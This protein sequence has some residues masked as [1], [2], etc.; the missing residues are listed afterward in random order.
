M[1]KIALLMILVVPCL[2]FA[3]GSDYW[4]KNKDINFPIG[5]GTTACSFYNNLDQASEQ[6][7]VLNEFYS[8]WMDGWVSSFAVYSDWNIRNIEKTE[9]ITFLKQYCKEF[10]DLTIARAAHT[11]T[12]RVKK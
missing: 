2:A 12:Y 10:P 4:S 7:K 1:K 11:F 9:Y 8:R 6:T 3:E 5:I